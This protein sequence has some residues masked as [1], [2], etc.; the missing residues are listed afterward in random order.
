MNELKILSATSLFENISEN[1]IQKILPC[2]KATK[3]HFRK[4]E[5]I[6][7]LGD[8]IKSIGVVLSG[9]VDIIKYDLWGNTHIIERM[10]TG[11]SFAE[12]YACQKNIASLVDVVASEESQ[13]LLINTDKILQKCTSCC[14]F[15]RVLIEN[16]LQIIAQKNLNLIKKIELL[17]PK[18]LRQ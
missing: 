5:Y 13:I 18:S 4:G 6:Y 11:G 2:L 10:N 7:R 8:K 16:L 17:T 3:H 14:P 9:S 12:A 15:H 1:E